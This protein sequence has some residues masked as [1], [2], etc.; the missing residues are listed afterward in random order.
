MNDSPNTGRAGRY[1]LIGLGVILAVVLIGFLWIVVLAPHAMDF[2]G[3]QHV[4]LTQ[5]HGEDPT[6]V[7]AELKGASLIERDIDGPV[8]R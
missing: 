7:P 2:A 4:A 1:T 6:G 8:E 3:G 5:Y